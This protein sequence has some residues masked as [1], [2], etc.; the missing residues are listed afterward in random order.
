MKSKEKTLELS[1]ITRHK[2]LGRY[3]VTVSFYSVG[4]CV[5]ERISLL[6]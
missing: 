6:T 5:Y 3:R 2:V 4:N 1:R